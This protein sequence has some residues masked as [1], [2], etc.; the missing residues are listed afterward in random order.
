MSS[1]TSQTPQECSP[2]ISAANLREMLY[3]NLL[4]SVMNR[5]KRENHVNKLLLVPIQ[6]STDQH[7]EC[8]Q[9]HQGTFWTK[10]LQEVANELPRLLLPL[11]NEVYALLLHLLHKLL[12]LLL[13]IPHLLLHFVHS[14]LQ[15]VLLLLEGQ[16]IKQIVCTMGQG[17]PTFF[18]L[19]AT[20][21]K[22]I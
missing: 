3:V 10:H 21:T 8:L 15:V 18:P 14:L 9:T 2:C 19:R 22:S 5:T 13:Y 1:G 11:L 4:P 20:P 6:S 12:T 17:C 7:L 16:E